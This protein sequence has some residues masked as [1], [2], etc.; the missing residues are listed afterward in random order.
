[1][2]PSQSIN[3]YLL[4]KSIAGKFLIISPVLSTDE[5]SPPV[6]RCQRSVSPFLQ[7]VE[8]PSSRCHK[9]EASSLGHC[10]SLHFPTRQAQILPVSLLLQLD[11]QG[12]VSV[13][14][15]RRSGQLLSHH[16][17]CCEICWS[18]HA[19]FFLAT[20][21]FHHHISSAG[22][23]PTCHPSPSPSE[24]PQELKIRQRFKE[25]NMSKGKQC[26]LMWY[27]LLLIITI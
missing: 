5:W 14:S 21:A 1:M 8:V 27:I 18:P 13:G 15:L 9:S 24:S 25:L 17:W 22:N 19:A 23:E 4:M 6:P 20:Q 10:G 11:I 26:K 2:N 16:L 3:L 7:S 12:F